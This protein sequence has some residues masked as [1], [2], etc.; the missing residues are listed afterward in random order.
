MLLKVT[1]RNMWERENWPYVIDLSKQ[2]ASTIN[3]LMIFI[4]LANKQFEEDKQN[5]SRNGHGQCFASSH[6][7]FDF[8][9]SYEDKKG[10][11]ILKNR[12][13]NLHLGNRENDYTS[14]GLRLDKVI[15][16]GKIKS[17]M[18]AIR[19]KKTNKLYK[20]FESVFLKK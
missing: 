14:S 12:K 19:D 15:S 1:E 5:A 18:T 10:S 2:E 4:R 17:A 13:M 16:A 7:S 6:Y 3:Y 8:F 9:D 20:D 11:V